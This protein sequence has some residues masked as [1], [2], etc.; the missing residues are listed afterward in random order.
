MLELGRKVLLPE[1]LGFNSPRVTTPI[2]STKLTVS[3][4]SS[5]RFCVK[6]NNYF[7]FSSFCQWKVEVK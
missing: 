4:S 3:S 1:T 7:S 6:I 5:D 2:F